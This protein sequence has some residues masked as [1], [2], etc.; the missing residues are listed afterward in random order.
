MIYPFKGGSS[1]TASKKNQKSFI[2]ICYILQR[3][4][5][6]MLSTEIGEIDSPFQIFLDYEECFPKTETFLALDSLHLRN[7]FSGHNEEGLFSCPWESSF[8][9]KNGEC[10]GCTK[11]CDFQMDCPGGDDEGAVCENILPQGAY[12]TFEEGPCHWTANTTTGTSWTY[13]NSVQLNHGDNI[14][15]LPTEGYFLYLPIESEHNGSA[16]TVYSDFFP[17]VLPNKTCQFTMKF[18]VFGLFNGTLAAYS[19]EENA[20]ASTSKLWQTEGSHSDSWSSATVK[21]PHINDRRY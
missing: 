13:T 9:C 18:L 14:H 1:K 15:P 12:C 4:H 19:Q 7:C 3:S 5:W 17:P 20:G 8:L 21:I 16:A 10:I 2:K 6:R 11:L